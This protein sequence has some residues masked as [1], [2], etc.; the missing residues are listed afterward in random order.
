MSVV[1]IFDVGNHRIELLQH[2]ISTLAQ[3]E[4]KFNGQKLYHPFVTKRVEYTVKTSKGSRTSSDIVYDSEGKFV[5]PEA[6]SDIL[7]AISFEMK[8][9]GSCGKIIWDGQKFVPYAR[10]DVRCKNGQFAQPP[11]NSIPC[12]PM[13]S[14]DDAVHWP[15]FVPLY[16][17]PNDYKW[18]IQ[19]YELMLTSKKLGDLQSSFTCEYMG[20]KFNWKACDSVGLDAAIVPHGLLTFQ[21]PKDL[22]TYKGIKQIMV[23]IPFI[24]GLV[25]YGTNN[26]WKIRREMFEYDG[27]KLQ[28]PSN[29]N[30]TTSEMVMMI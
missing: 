3:R 8:H 14:P 1:K 2:N 12:E 19:A 10:F 21:I 9:D 17:K 27:S 18:Y 30:T 16:D 20:K 28:W 24:E 29:A 22:R 4:S 11:A 13:P 7:N 26:I 25:V 6:E 15:H 23:D 5:S